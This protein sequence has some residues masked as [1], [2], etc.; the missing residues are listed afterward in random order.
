MIL[1]IFLP[2]KLAFI[3]QTTASFFQK[4]NYNVGFLEKRQFF[5]PKLAK[6]RRKL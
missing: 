6:N 3:A 1:K 2:K 4:F 5:H